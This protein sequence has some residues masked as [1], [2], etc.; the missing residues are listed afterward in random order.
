VSVK[1][2]RT[3]LVGVGMGM[4]MASAAGADDVT[5][6]RD[7]RIVT[8]SGPTLERGTVVIRDGK[9]ADVG[10]AVTIPPGATI[11]EGGG[12]TVYPGL[13]DVDT[14]VGLTEVPGVTMSDDY[15]EI[16]EITPHL[17]AFN[18]FHIDSAYVAIDRLAGV[19]TVVST[20]SGGMLP[21]QA[22]VMNLAGWTAAEMEVT[23]HGPLVLD[24][25][26]LLDFDPP[27]YQ[28]R[29]RP[30]LDNRPAPVR[31][32]ELKDFFAAT[33]AYAEARG[34]RGSTDPALADARYEALLPALEGRTTV[35]ILVDS[36]VDMRAAVAFAQ[37]EKLPR[38]ALVGAT[39]AWKIAGFL[40]ENRVSVIL[41]GVDRPPVREDDPIDV[42]CRTP[43]LLHQQGVPFTVATRNPWTD[44]RGLR[45]EIGFAVGCG[46]PRDAAVRSLT[47]TAAEMLGLADRLGSID[48]GKLANL[49]VYDGDILEYGTHLRRLFVNGRAIPLTSRHTELYERYKAR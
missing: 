23:R 30:F 5:A 44:A 10:E 1:G 3:V 18:A 12:L 25:P 16:G 42:M 28:K 17:L 38:Y 19:T 40:K 47:L 4:V 31:V 21:G 6:I 15:S 2:L 34:R 41:G 14:A 45:H 7:V 48:K 24:Y 27:P 33:R 13:I 39:D 22:S 11:V 35:Y 29:R 8:V 36:E 9:I 43:A 46:L 26:K 32:R 49:V 20:P 37:E